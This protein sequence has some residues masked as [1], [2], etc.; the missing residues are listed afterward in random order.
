MPN[1]MDF[2]RP[3]K[4]SS[5]SLNMPSTNSRKHSFRLQRHPNLQCRCKDQVAVAAFAVF[6]FFFL[7]CLTTLSTPLAVP[8]HICTLL[9]QRCHSSSQVVRHMPGQEHRCQA[10]PW[11][12]AAGVCN[13]Y[14]CKPVPDSV[15]FRLLLFFLCSGCCRLLP[16]ASVANAAAAAKPCRTE[17]RLPGC[18]A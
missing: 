16:G 5:R 8:A 2:I 14:G 3:A 13:F 7:G 4:F 17:S 18:A 15:L 1:A 6:T 12:T 10:N 9:C 11:R